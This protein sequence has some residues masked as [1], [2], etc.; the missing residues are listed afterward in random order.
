MKGMKI[1]TLLWIR[2]ME[3]HPWRWW[4]PQE[5]NGEEQ[6]PGYEPELWIVIR[7][8]TV[9]R[10]RLCKPQTVN[11][12]HLV[13][14]Y[15]CSSMYLVPENFVPKVNDQ[16]CNWIISLD[17]HT[18]QLS[19]K[20]LCQGSGQDTPSD[21]WCEFHP[22]EQYNSGPALCLCAALWGVIGVC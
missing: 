8:Q 5:C 2:V 13:W 3:T 21:S 14:I 9:I 16:F 20:G 6:P 11:N 10:R 7:L 18:S 4:C 1:C 17:Y 22:G 12:Q 19:M 15:G